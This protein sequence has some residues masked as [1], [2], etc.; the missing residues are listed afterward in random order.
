MDIDT[1]SPDAEPEVSRDL[2]LAAIGAIYAY[3]AD[4]GDWHALSRLFEVVGALPDDGRTA[5]DDPASREFGLHMARAGHLAQAAE[6][7]DAMGYVLIDRSNKVVAVNE[8]GRNLVAPFCDSVA[9]DQVL[10]FRD[11]DMRKALSTASADLWSSVDGLQLLRLRDDEEER[12]GFAYLIAENRFPAVLALMSASVPA[13][14]RPLR[15]LVAPAQTV[16]FTDDAILQDVIGLTAAE[17]RL[18]QRL[19]S[20]MAVKDAADELGIAVATARNQLRAIFDK[21]SVTRQT[22]MV[23]D[24]FSLGALASALRGPEPSA[25]VGDGDHGERRFFELGPGHRLSYRQYGAADGIPVFLL[26]NWGF[27]SLQPPWVHNAALQHG[28]R[29]IAVERPGTG[30]STPDNTMTHMSFADIMRRLA[31]ALGLASFRVMGHA[32]GAAFALTLASHVPD[33]VDAVML[34]STRLAAPDRRRE[35]NPISRSFYN[36][37]RRMP[38]LVE[39]TGPILRSRM[40]RGL[41][42]SMTLGFYPESS[43]DHAILMQDR[44]LLEYMTDTT[45]EAVARGYGGIYHEASLLVG[46]LNIEPSSVRAPIVAW[47]GEQNDLVPLETAREWLKAYPQCDFHV[48]PDEGHLLHVRRWDE[49]FA[50]LRAMA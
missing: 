46:G 2:M 39:A 44:A 37:V 45:I 38:W 8:Q 47:H 6:P 16:V 9:P 42:R 28:I 11:P 27:S 13:G 24:L 35:S 19:Q 20:G 30:L 12:T 21:L 1:G 31:D 3:A 4:P 29:L 10:R 49:A 26:S 33:R 43:V 22:D 15:A 7:V 34:R 23:R 40:T 50:S 25:G 18:A 32:A 17:A 14:A 36:A 41:V 48:M 5:E